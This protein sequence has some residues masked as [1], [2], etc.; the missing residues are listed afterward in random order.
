MVWSLGEKGRRRLGISMQK[1]GNCRNAGK[2]RPAKRWNE[3]VKDGLKR[4]GLDGGLAKDGE[5]W[6]AQGMEKT[7]ELCE[8]GQGM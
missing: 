8:H 2:G 3:V 5:R 4:C 7:S 6:K 1:Y